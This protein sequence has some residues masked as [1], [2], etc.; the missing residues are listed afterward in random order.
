MS[1]FLSVD[2][3]CEMLHFRKSYLYRLV[4]ERAI[5][6]YKP[7]NGRILFEETELENFVRK[8]RVSTQ[9]ELSEKA[10]AILNQKAV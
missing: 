7:R 4:H 6:C 5:P 9:Q 1:K 2:E 3:A 10:D 8:G